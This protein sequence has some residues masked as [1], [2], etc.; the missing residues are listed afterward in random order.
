[1]RSAQMTLAI[2]AA[3]AMSLAGCASGSGTAA[4]RTALA[5]LCP[6]PTPPDRLRA[7]AD[8]LERAQPDPGLDVLATEWERLD[9]GVRILRGEE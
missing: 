7:I 5:G 6:A 9:D 2:A 4:D 8:Y 3:L 1:M